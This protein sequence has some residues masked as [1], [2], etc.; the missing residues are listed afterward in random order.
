MLRSVVWMTSALFAAV[1]TLGGAHFVAA[2][3][4]AA[5]HEQIQSTANAGRSE[6]VEVRKGVRR[7]TGG[8][9]IKVRPGNVTVNVKKWPKAHY[10][11]YRGRR[12]NDGVRWYY[13]APWASAYLVFNSY[14]ACYSN[15]RNR[16]KSEAYCSDVCSP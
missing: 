10:R 6:I 16:G 8:K 13:W 2:A 12:W 9:H 14:D 1:V 11:V 7:V 15:C 3:P 5:S 4:F